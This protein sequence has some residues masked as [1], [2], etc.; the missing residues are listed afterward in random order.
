MPNQDAAMQS[1]VVN[2]NEA[3]AIASQADGTTALLS[4][5]VNDNP[6]IQSEGAQQDSIGQP[7]LIPGNLQGAPQ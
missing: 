4:N 7:D 2:N 1:N 3:S 5:V 6:I